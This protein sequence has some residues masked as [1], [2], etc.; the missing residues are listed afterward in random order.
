MIWLMNIV[1]HQTEWAKQVN[2]GEKSILL[3]HLP[4]LKLKSSP[5]VD[6][7]GLGA[8]SPESQ[9]MIPNTNAGLWVMGHRWRVHNHPKNSS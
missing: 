9:K 1:Y 2:N 7:L 6:G 8:S 3:C 5:E 4:I